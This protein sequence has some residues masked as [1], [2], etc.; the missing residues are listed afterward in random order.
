MRDIKR[1]VEDLDILSYMDKGREVFYKELEGY[2][3]EDPTLRAQV[4][5]GE[6]LVRGLIFA[7]IRAKALDFVS[8]YEV[9]SIEEEVRVPLASN[10]TLAARAD[11][12]VRSRESGAFYVWNWKTTSG[13]PSPVTWTG[14]WT[15]AVQMWTEALA[16]EDH[17]GVPIQGCIV[18]GLCK[19]YR[20]DGKYSSPLVYGWK[21]HEVVD[22]R[23]SMAF[24]WEYERT[25]GWDKFNAWEFPV[26]G[27]NLTPHEAWL[28]GLP[29]EVLKAQLVRSE[30]ILKNNAVVEGWLRQVVERETTIQH[31]LA[32]GQEVD[33]EALLSYFSQH[34][35][36]QC[37][38]CPFEPVCTEKST[39][40]GLIGSGLLR[41]RRDHHEEVPTGG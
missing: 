4:V 19:G 30:P 10:V 14:E 17:L 39:I 23:E 35:T 32:G 5:E 3:I 38:W 33:K 26:N 18:E 41:E 36:S 11:A 1:G 27:G 9:I 40:E 16:I 12:V 22:G 8:E 15:Y 31:L 20:K 24:S 34:W 25:K 28:K 29:M 21:K 7:W 37:K 13:R 2:T 6:H